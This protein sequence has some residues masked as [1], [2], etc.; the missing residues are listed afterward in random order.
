MS[1]ATPDANGE[2]VVMLDTGFRSLVH[3]DRFDV[4]P[5]TYRAD[6]RFGQVTLELPTSA[7]QRET[8]AVWSALAAEAAA[9]ETAG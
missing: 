1:D 9:A 5:S 8:K 3:P 6:T 2:V 7:D 4:A